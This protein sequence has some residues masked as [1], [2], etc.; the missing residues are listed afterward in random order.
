MPTVTKECVQRLARDVKNLIKTPLTSCG[1]YY[2]HDDTNML[3][4][5]AMVC[6]PKDTPYFGGYYFV[7]FTFPCNYPHV[8]PLVTYCTIDGYTRFHPNLYENGKVCLSVL[9]TWNGEQWTSCQNI[10]SVLLYLC[11]ILSHQ[12][13]LYEP[14]VIRTDPKVDI[15]E[16]IVQYSNVNGAICSIINGDIYKPFFDKF[17][18]P[19]LE[20]FNDNYE[21]IVGFCNEQLALGVNLFKK[22]K[23][24][25]HT[26]YK[27]S[28]QI[29]Y[30]GLLFKL[31]ECHNMRERITESGSLKK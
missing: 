10:S 4:G 29:N 8:P 12:A 3:K 13:L 22:K 5:Y 24:V 2:E 27:M 14:G 21:Y 15:F 31:K 16:K 30:E 18:T 25:L 17:I 28:V 1:I 7:E 11:S 20:N 23:Y 19:I 9:N 6:G 26:V